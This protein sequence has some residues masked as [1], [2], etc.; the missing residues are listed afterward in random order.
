MNKTQK[1]KTERIVHILSPKEIEDLLDFG[2]TR[3]DQAYL[4]ALGR[5]QKM[6]G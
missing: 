4:Y 5:E 6:R 1:Q 3:L 2:I